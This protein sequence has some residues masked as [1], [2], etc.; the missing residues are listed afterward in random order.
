M[1]RAHAERLRHVEHCPAY[2]GPCPGQCFLRQACEND[3]A[4]VRE[5]IGRLDDET[6]EALYLIATGRRS[7]PKRGEN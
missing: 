1:A 5:L 4:A 2:Q 6:V 3:P 7:A